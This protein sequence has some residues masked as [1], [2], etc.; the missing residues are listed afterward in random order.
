MAKKSVV[1]KFVNMQPSPVQV[2]DENRRLVTV[3]PWQNR[4]RSPKGNYVVEGEHYAKFVSAKGPLAPFPGIDAV[5]EATAAKIAKLEER[6]AEKREESN[7]PG[8]AAVAS[9]GTAV[10]A[11]DDDAVASA[12]AGEDG[13][14]DTAGADDGGDAGAGAAGRAATPAR[15]KSAKRATKKTVK[16]TKRKTKRKA[17]RKKPR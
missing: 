1:P 11:G 2:P 4:Q 16:K 14:A 15:G 9:R 13:G 10:S 6:R 17:T 5:E 3:H 8:L 7:A 12:G